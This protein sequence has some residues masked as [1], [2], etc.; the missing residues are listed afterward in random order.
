VGGQQIQIV[1]AQLINQFHKQPSSKLELLMKLI[2]S[3]GILDL[4]SG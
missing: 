2:D 4:L 1:A 3:F